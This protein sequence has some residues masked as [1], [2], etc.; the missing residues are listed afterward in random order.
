MVPWL[1][2]RNLIEKMMAVPVVPNPQ[3]TALQGVMALLQDPRFGSIE[4]GLQLLRL[5]PVSIGK[6]ATVEAAITP[7]QL[8][9]LRNTGD[10]VEDKVH[11]IEIQLFDEA[12]H[13][14]S[15]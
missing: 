3:K 14:N 8:A 1:E 6:P 5:I 7:S 10:S 15:R 2:A 11:W 13:A 4:E 9:A 12:G